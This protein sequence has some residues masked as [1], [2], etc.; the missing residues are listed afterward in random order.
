MTNVLEIEYIDPIE[1]KAHPDNAKIHTDKQI[2]RIAKSMDNTGGSV[3]PIVVAEDNVILAGHGRWMA[4]K[5]RG[6]TDCPIVRKR[7]LTAAQQ[8]KFLLADNQTN[9]MTGNA[10]DSVAKILAELDSEGVEISDIG[11]SEK[12][13]DKFLNFEEDNDT[14]E[15]ADSPTEAIGLRELK[16]H[17]VITAAECAGAY[18]FPVLTGHDCPVFPD[19]QEFVVWMNRHRTEALGKGQMYYNLHGRE[20]TKG[21]DPQQTMVSFYID[22]KR[23]ESIYTKLRDNTQRFLN[24]ALHSITMPDFSRATG[25]PLPYNLWNAYRNFY[26]AHYW[27]RAGLPVVPNLIAWDEASIEP[28]SDPIPQHIHTVSCQIQTLG[29][30]TMRFDKNNMTGWEADDYRAMFGAQLDLIKP[31]TMIVYGGAPGLT[32]G[33][34]ICKRQGV[35]FI[36]VANRATAATELD[37]ERGF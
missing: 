3:Q 5:K 11:F 19:S 30:R 16:E 26:C 31:E 7:G 20:S 27:E 33:E 35:R 13:L 1:L 22:D 25:A 17:L 12:E 18:D 21:L 24:A 2:D 15:L 32:L 23:F 4:H 9:A 34:E 14:D 10:F 37:Q 29:G 28:C 6:D 8:R 36:G